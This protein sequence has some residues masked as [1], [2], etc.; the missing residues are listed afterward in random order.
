MAEKNKNLCD[1]IKQI[2]FYRYAHPIIIRGESIDIFGYYGRDDRVFVK[3]HYSCLHNLPNSLLSL[4][5]AE[6]KLRSCES[7]LF[8]SRLTSRMFLNHD[9]FNSSGIYLPTPLDD[10]PAISKIYLLPFDNLPYV[11]PY[12]IHK[13]KIISKNSYRRWNTAKSR[14]IIPSHH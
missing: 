14:N 7:N 4:R 12:R 5:L 6:S 8:Y 11:R 9:S 2:S 10:K 13:K 3:Y 1:A